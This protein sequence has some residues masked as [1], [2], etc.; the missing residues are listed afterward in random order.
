MEFSQ[1]F[2]IDMALNASGYLL[3]GLLG[4]VVYAMFRK[5]RAAPSATPSHEEAAADEKATPPE[6]SGE[7][8]KLEFIRLGQGPDKISLA[9]SSVPESGVENS[10]RRRDRAETMRVA[11]SMLKAGA[12]HEQIRRVIPVS[13]AELSLL[14]MSKS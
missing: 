12:S 9:A 13:E 3:A 7:S 14:S 11:R 10:A 1:Q 8:R 4:M 6:P 2:L 5:G